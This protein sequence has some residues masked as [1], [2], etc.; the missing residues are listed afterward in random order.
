MDDLK[1]FVE[2]ISRFIDDGIDS[3]DSA[4]EIIS[5]MNAFLYTTEKDL[6][7]IEEFGQSFQFFSK[8]HRY[9]YE[10]HKEILDLQIDDEKCCQVAS[11]LHEVFLRTSGRAFEQIYDTCGLEKED[12]CRI[13]LL[14]AN[15]DFRGSRSFKEYAELFL[16]DPS[17][18]D[19]RM[20]YASPENFVKL[21]GTTSLSQNDKRGQYAKR[22]AQFLLEYQKTP[23]EIIQAFDGDLVDFRDALISYQA[24]YGYKKAN[25]LI[26]DMVVLKIWNSKRNFDQIDVASDVN[27]IKVAL[28]TGIM[29]SAI[30]LVSSFLDIFCYQYEYVDKRVVQ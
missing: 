11:A 17:I 12:V 30:P 6:G 22:I 8:F 1:E 29:Q 7:Q 24:G 9:W 4:R 26:R 16:S 3:I 28:R 25:M 18:F 23:Y 10:H 15:Q 14:T 27:T 13:R 5:R 19:E 21:I 2:E 20:I